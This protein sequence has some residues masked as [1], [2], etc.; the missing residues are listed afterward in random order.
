[1]QSIMART[2]LVFVYTLNL[3]LIECTGKQIDDSQSRRERVVAV[4]CHCTNWFAEFKFDL[5]KSLKWKW[6]IKTNDGFRWRER[7]RDAWKDRIWWEIMCNLLTMHL[8]KKNNAKNQFS[9]S[10][11]RTETHLMWSIDIVFGFNY[12]TYCVCQ[13]I[14]SHWNSSIHQTRKSIEFPLMCDLPFCMLN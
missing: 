6:K 1:M 9:L 4:A 7:E 13:A 14:H 3:H 11:T 2:I 5:W 12:Y 10:A 8:Q